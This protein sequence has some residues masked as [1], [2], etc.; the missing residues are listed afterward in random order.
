[1][2]TPTTV[3]TGLPINGLR[4]WLKAD[5][6]LAV[7]PVA[8]WQDQSGM[9]NHA[10]QGSNGALPVLVAN[11]LNGRPVVRFDGNSD[12][13]TLP[14]V[15]A[16]ASAAEIIAVLR[17]PDA[18]SRID[19]LWH[20]GT[21]NASLYYNGSRYD[22]F[23][24]NNGGNYSSPPVASLAQYHFY[25]VSLGGGTWIER[26]NGI[27]QL[28]RTGQALAFRSDP[29]IGKR[30]GY[31]E[32]LKGDV[33]EILLYDRVLT[34]LEREAAY[35]Y[36]T[37]KYALPTIV[38]PAAA[39][40]VQ[41][42]AVSSTEVSLAWSV[43]SAGSPLVATIERRTGADEFEF[44]TEVQSDLGYTDTGL[45]PETTYD[46]RVKLRSFAG[47]SD[48]SATASATPPPG[49]PETPTSGLR[50]W[51]EAGRGTQGVGSLG[52]WQ[53]QSGRGAHATQSVSSARPQVVADVLNGRPVVRFDGSNDYLN[54]PHVMNGASAGEIIAVLR[55]PYAGTRIDAL[56]HFG[57]GNGSLYYQG[58]RYDDFGTNFGGNY[59]SPPIAS[60]AQFH[61][62]NVSIGNGTWIERLNGTERLR[63]TGQ[64]Q[65]FRGD[66]LIGK[67]QGYSEFFRGDIA[68]LLIYDRVL[69]D[70][71]RAIAHLNLYRKY[72]LGH[73]TLTLLP[74]PGLYASQ[75]QVTIHSPSQAAEIY[76]TLDD[77]T[78]VR[79]VSLRYTG[80]IT[81]TQ[82]TR[83]RARGFIGE[84]F[85]TDEVSGFYAIGAL[86]EPV[87]GLSGLSA[88]YYTDA[89]FT[90]S[91]T[92]RIDAQISNPNFAT[93]PA[94][95]QGT[96]AS[97]E[98]TGELVAQ[99]SESHGFA[100]KTNGGVRLWF[101]GDL[102]IDDWNGTG[103]REITF[104]KPLV[105]GARY[106]VRLEFQRKAAASELTLEW[107]SYSATRAVVPQSQ[108]ASG[109]THASAAA[110]PV[111]NPVG[112]D[113]ADV[114]TLSLAAATP[115]TGARIHYTLDGTE[116]TEASALYAGPITLSEPAQL[117][118]R[119]YADDHT[120]SGLR[121]ASYRPSSP[122][123]SRA[124]THHKVE[125]GPSSVG[126]GT[127]TELA[128]EIGGNRY[129]L[130]QSNVIAT[131]PVNH[132]SLPALTDTAI[133]SFPVG[134]A[135]GGAYVI[136]TPMAFEISAVHAASQINYNGAYN[137]PLYIKYY[138]STDGGATWDLLMTASNIS[139]T[140]GYMRFPIDRPGV[141]FTPAP[142]LY[143]GGVNVSLASGL[144]NS[145]IYYT[146]DGSAPVK[147]ASSLYDGPIALTAS[148]LVRARPYNDVVHGFEGSAL[149]LVGNASEPVTPASG[150]A[151][152][153]FKERDFGGSS[154]RRMDAALDNPNVATLPVG[155]QGEGISA[156]WEAELIARFTE[157]HTF[158]L[159]TNGGVR[160]WF[161]DV[162][163]VDDWAGSTSRVLTFTQPLTAG[164]RYP[165][166]VEF[167]RQS[168][169]APDLRL[170]WSGFS[171]PIELIP[172]S[173]Y[174]SLLGNTAPNPGVAGLNGEYHIGTALGGAPVLTR[175]ED[176]NFIWSG[177]PHPS[178]PADRFSVRW[179]GYVFPT[180]T[181]NHTFS[182]V[183]DDGVR[184]WIGDQL[185]I[186]DWN[187]HGATTNTSAAIALNANIPVSVR[188]EYY[189]NG[190]G[191]EVR[192][193]WSYPGQS[194]AVAIPL[195]RLSTSQG[196]F[197]TTP[198]ATP[199][200][201]TFSANTSV[202]LAT[203]LPANA[204]I[205]YTLDGSEPTPSSTLYTGPFVISQSQ[206]LKARGYASGF[207]ESGVLVA[208][209]T[210]VEVPPTLSDVA[211][212]GQSL[213]VLLSNSGTA[214]VMATAGESASFSVT[215]SGVP[216]PTYQWFK[217]GGIIAGA[218]NATYS[219]AGLQTGDAGAYSVVVTNS[220]GSAS[221]GAATLVVAIPPAILTQPLG[222]EGTVG[223]S[224][225]FDVAATAIPAP[226]YQWRKGGVVISGATSATYTIAAVS[227]GDAGSYSV[228][229]S[230]PAGSVA[231]DDA[232]LSINVP[233]TVSLTQP[234]ANSYLALPATVHLAA[235]ASDADGTVVK[236]EFFS[237][238]IKVGEAASAPYTYD[239][240]MTT[241]GT[242]VLTARAT[243]NLGA[244]TTSAPVQ[245]QALPTLPY[246]ADFETAEGYATG[247]L[248]GQLGWLVVAGA[249]EITPTTAAQGTQSVVLNAGAVAARVDQEFAPGET[250]P[251]SVFIDFF[252]KPVAGDDP[253]TATT[254]DV[255]AAQVAFVRDGDS[256]FYRVLD[257][258]GLGAGVWRT[259]AK[260]IAVMSNG[261]TNAWQRITLAVHYTTKTWDLYVAGAPIAA[262]LGF[263]DDTA[264]RLIAVAI[265]GHVDASAR[266]DAL[267][268][269]AVNPL[270]NDT[271]SDGIDDAWETGHGFSLASANRN[272]D[273][274]DDGL[275]NFEEYML[276][277][278]PTDADTDGD[279]LDDRLEMT[280]GTNPSVPDDTGTPLPVAGARLHLRSDLG[281][282]ND[283]LGFTEAWHDLSGHGYD[284]V[285]SDLLRQPLVM[286]GELNGFPVVRFDPE[287]DTVLVLPDVM[288][289]ADRGEAFAVVRRA[290]TLAVVG[291]WAFGSHE[292]G[293]RYP[294]VGGGILDDFA[295][296]TWT[297]TGPEP[298][299]LTDFHI[300]N[301]GG[302][303]TTWFQYF[304][305]YEH[306]RRLNNT[307]GFSTTPSI[308]D[309]RGAHFDGDIAEIIVYDR[310]LS[311]PERAAV[312]AYLATK[313]A[314]VTDRAAPSKPGDLAPI[315]VAPSSFT[316]TWTASTDNVGVDSYYIYL[317]GEPVGVSPT[318]SFEITGLNFGT[319]YT[320]SVEAR[321]A[322]GNT[323]AM[324]DSLEVTT[325]AIP[326][327]GL[328]LWLKAD[329]GITQDGN[330]RVSEWAD[331]SGRGNDATQATAASRP[332]VVANGFSAVRFDAT[333]DQFLDLPNFM[334]APSTASAGDVF[335]VLRAT[336]AMP[337]QIRGF[338]HMG[339]VG[340]SQY[341]ERDGMIYDTFGSS[342]QRTVGTPSAPISDFNIYNVSSAPG[343][344][345]ARLNGVIEASFASNTVVFPTDPK[346]GND[347]YSSPFAGDIA[348]L[349]VYDRIL[350]DLEREDIGYYLA[351]KYSPPAVF[352]PDAPVLV[353]SAASSTSVA[354]SWSAPPA[355]E[356]HTAAFIERARIDEDFETIALVG[357]ATTHVDTGLTAGATYTYR[358]T[359]RSYA[360]VS[361]Y[362]DWVTVTLPTVV[363]S[364]NSTVGAGAFD[365]EDN[366]LV[367]GGDVTINGGISIKEARLIDGASLT[368]DSLAT[369][370]SVSLDSASLITD[371]LTVGDTL[372]LANGSVVT[373]R[374][375]T[376]TT[377]HGLQIGASSVIVDAT[378]RI[379]VTG[380][381]Y[382]GGYTSG[383]STYSAT[384]A[385]GSHGGLGGS[386][387]ANMG[388]VYGDF[389]SPST[390]G[391][392]AG[393]AATGGTGGGRIRLVTDSLILDGSLSADGQGV[394]SGV[395]SGGGAGGSVWV[396]VD[397][398][399]GSGSIS[400]NGGL[401]Q[402]ATLGGGGG[403]RV[404]LYYDWSGFDLDSITAFGGGSA[405]L[406][407]HD[408]SA[409]TVYF[410]RL[411]DHLPGAGSL[412]VD[413]QGRVGTFGTPL[414]GVGR[415]V[416]SGIGAGQLFDST[417][418]FSAG[419]AG[420]WVQP[421]IA[422]E[423]YFR[424][425]GNS[426]TSLTVND[427][428]S[429]ADV[430][431]VGDLYR[432]IVLLGSA[433]VRGQAV[434][435]SEDRLVLTNS[436]LALDPN[437]FWIQEGTLSYYP[438]T[439][440]ANDVVG[441]ADGTVQ[442]ATLTED[443][444]WEP[445]RAYSFDG[446]DSIE[447]GLND[448]GAAGLDQDI[449]VS[450]WVKLDPSA[451]G[452]QTIVSKS[453]DANTTTFWFG[454]S[455][456]GT[457]LGAGTTSAGGGEVIDYDFNEFY[458]D[459]WV[460]V[461]CFYDKAQ[462]QMTLYVNDQAV[463]SWSTG[464]D[465]QLSTTNTE[466]F[467]V[468]AI[469]ENGTGEAFF[470]GSI[471]EVI[472]ADRV[473]GER[474]PPPPAS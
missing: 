251:S 438:F 426:A 54:L 169:T 454:L 245:V 465:P 450:A 140:S 142:G 13:L 414:R 235:S 53:D 55:A 360:G 148:T 337:A 89:N 452:R 275:T 113:Y 392:G 154:T 349:I 190:G 424:I 354:L 331:R 310:V 56:W 71:E 445:G 162:L 50:L 198:T 213:P 119:T 14:H 191:A 121:I 167:Q 40:N 334:H 11:A 23:G 129:F 68:E 375:T 415:G 187:D 106:G 179:T 383:F 364:T 8:R 252:A 274:D 278:D 314:I 290:S 168:L 285:Q 38:V 130:N 185:V 371:E 188:L 204:S 336:E 143:P 33:S 205:Y 64:T 61:F 436:P 324:S 379:D 202:A 223:E 34:P 442:G 432:G 378:S 380:K 35:V 263:R 127:L 175:N 3:T 456:D 283:D 440:A 117:K 289:G 207:I 197:V 254:I 299:Y 206:T 7:G 356:L 137:L 24:T 120:P 419:L 46:Y 441:S 159:N 338:W 123:Y 469:R 39:T 286:A 376:S 306:Y 186:N 70:G 315:D 81:I 281:V 374:A 95:W 301:V 366:L 388:E 139:W 79:G 434:V 257:G 389:R 357:D 461:A 62:Y 195:G 393:D 15:M 457:R 399:E 307:V 17:A 292:Y 444:N 133:N 397:G 76:Y 107:S 416:V 238:G 312:G 58:S 474:D 147:P 134:I 22:D 327:M 219:L 52:I 463:K 417:A 144:S 59:S 87:T 156:R 67:R 279:G 344:W 348:E 260:E 157:N 128:F 72:D 316:L 291:L 108:L 460:K 151:A 41:A 439:G 381:G 361:D 407:A 16:A 135:A 266:F 48:Y 270:F 166:K 319:T 193:R 172:Q 83:V 75:V 363:I 401:G 377:A 408:G 423:T 332:T 302:D 384:T 385:G 372:S 125:V 303:A 446:D 382:P 261:A 92:R 387:T 459:S 448:L 346:L 131:S 99:F 462:R 431:Q 405:D 158:T 333:A 60:L 124:V 396:Q 239:W 404:A 217:N 402:G 19:A 178:I 422:E 249:A 222:K 164:S 200:G 132:G 161:D 330:G 443:R 294:E 241:L 259:T 253:S 433:T 192:L 341:P 43:P 288:A 160:L 269:G 400:A 86:S 28:R 32:Y 27:E 247:S 271:N 91:S 305:T 468:G 394:E 6:G 296:N 242:V 335:V 304:N 26:L 31:N 111:A 350:T 227:A 472:I 155:W 421:D 77:T 234:P 177:Q 122:T 282:R 96:S 449:Y 359:L 30:H 12:H 353:A 300:Y 100:L 176:V 65:V 57:A 173:Q 411:G 2:T 322:F 365:T 225:S 20:F 237:D 102:V 293:N 406:S 180:V 467:V 194:S 208:N 343:S 84:S 88:T 390:L 466:P 295:S 243:D 146:L 47:S 93:L 311:G 218:T 21:S 94:D 215:A 351:S 5:A 265:T 98:W 355:A 268:V 367:L 328:R 214:A 309:G 163:V 171:T 339:G 211:F 18:G 323:S 10:V 63:R 209:Y 80:P 29:L 1:M 4:L 73:Q 276:G 340:N 470:H 45:V 116:P 114:V 212:N 395:S 352:V 115:S 44:L 427:T 248:D 226:T 69:T 308:G 49:S 126:T 284:A 165:L 280:L 199:A 473:V 455:A 369:S 184:L 329:S 262:N 458:R 78:P 413:G 272:L 403:G 420:L 170:R 183:S 221:S 429:F 109:L 373:S 25:N 391:A 345:V 398:L 105:A 386:D 196:V 256:G 37:A 145:S 358:V 318:N 232:V 153:Y 141:A 425:T 9:G 325:E 228:V 210:F 104:N 370:G 428:G 149:Y 258:D 453:L 36:L 287:R 42:T 230:N 244:S 201:G 321:D 101:N 297:A 437:S 181:G 430:A 410:E 203:S 435:Y 216:A 267:Y 110:T 220:M 182:T 326:A 412:I 240:S 118:A 273:P 362:G 255:G 368:V 277:S 51:L 231:S 409:G 236:V 189:E 74:A 112:G 152:T 264:T 85:S 246:V 136:V 82:S 313:Y 451:T 66:P 298:D 233:P 347:Y 250:N 471:D 464:A 174:D 229:V 224:V 138:T 418:R 150:L 97:A 90:G 320:V 317:D 342:A 447:L 103:S